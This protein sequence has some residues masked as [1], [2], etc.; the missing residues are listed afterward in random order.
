MAFNIL[1][2]AQF[3]GFF[4]LIAEAPVGSEHTVDFDQEVA[5]SRMTPRQFFCDEF[6][7]EG[8]RAYPGEMTTD[9]TATRHAGRHYVRPV[10]TDRPSHYLNAFRT[11]LLS[12][13]LQAL[14]YDSPPVETLRQYMIAG[15]QFT[16]TH[17]QAV[18]LAV[19][20]VRVT[21]PWGAKE[22]TAPAIIDC[23]FGANQFEAITPVVLCEVWI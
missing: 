6:D 11:E 4:V 17:N 21:G 19:G 18:M 14:L 5:A 8:V 10:R 16:A 2:Q 22:Y 15:E 23:R 13:G 1:T 3:D 20:T 7:V 12:Q 9:N